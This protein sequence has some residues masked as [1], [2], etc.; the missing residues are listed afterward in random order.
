MKF[1]KE[2]KMFEAYERPKYERPKSPQTYSKWTK[3]GESS[4]YTV[5]GTGEKYIVYVNDENPDERINGL[6]IDFLKEFEP[7]LP[8]VIEP[9][10]NIYS[11]KLSGDDLELDFN[12]SVYL[13]DEKAIIGS[14]FITGETDDSIS[15][16]N[17]KEFGSETASFGDNALPYSVTIHNITLPKSKI[18]V[19]SEVEGKEGFSYIK[20]PY[21]LYKEN[22]SDLSIKRCKGTY[23]NMKRLDLRDVSLSNKELMSNFKDPNVVKYFSISNPDERTQQQ[24]RNYARM[25]G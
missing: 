25:A 2:F 23:H 19:I 11:N 14:Y 5:M 4:T 8:K 17:I 10:K 15:L 12:N 3:P 1:I 6:L 24:V 20:I 22:L 21:W 7:V 9:V 16:L 18:E 13:P